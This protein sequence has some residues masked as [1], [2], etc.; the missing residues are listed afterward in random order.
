MIDIRHTL[1]DAFATFLQLSYSKLVFVS[2]NLL[3]Y[4][5]PYNS[6]GEHVYPN[7]LYYAGEVPYLSQ[8]HL[9]FFILATIVFLVLVILPVLLLLFYPTK[10]FQRCLGFFSG[11]NWHP[12]HAFADAFN[13]CY[14][15]GT[16]GTWDMRYFGSFYLL[17]RVVC[18]T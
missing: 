3:S 17:F 7:V 18:F 14:K 15:N 10:T 11:I 9:P 16:N 13:G 6:K 4:V 2:F 8:T 5:A 1:I 12:L